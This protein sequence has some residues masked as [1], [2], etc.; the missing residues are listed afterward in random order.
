[1]SVVPRFYRNTIG[2]KA[3]MAVT[4]VI[5]TGWI[6]GHVLGNVL[7]FGGPAAVNAYAAALKSNMALLWGLRAFMLITVVLHVVA[8]VQLVRQQR[9]ARPVAYTR[10]VPQESTFASRTIRWGGL[11]LALFV[12]YHILH[13]TTGTVHPSFSHTDV[14]SN[15]VRG[16]R[17]PWVAAIYLVA[18]AALGLHLYHG[19]WS[20]F[21]SLGFAS[22]PVSPARRRLATVIAILVYIGFTAIPLAILF[23]FLDLR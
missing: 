10:Q 14:Y 15:M 6:V 1:V 23:R 4:G 16:L 22:S 21:Q 9:A 5:L 20:V 13:M 19:M 17:V 7:I 11:V 8:A 2:K 12:I 18:V 3:V